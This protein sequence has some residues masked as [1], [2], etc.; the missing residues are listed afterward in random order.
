VK[1]HSY[2]VYLEKSTV[3]SLKLINNCYDI[4]AFRSAKCVS[5]II[6]SLI[7][8]FTLTMNCSQLHYT[9]VLLYTYMIKQQM[10]FC[11]YMQSHFPF[12]HQYVSVTPVTFIRLSFN[13]ST[14][15]IQIIVQNFAIKPFSVTLDF[16]VLSLWP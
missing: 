6:M 5:G 14:I 3:R 15:S 11:K 16:S 9:Y 1:H 8:F 7:M 10:H 2:T 13:K 12:L 4:T